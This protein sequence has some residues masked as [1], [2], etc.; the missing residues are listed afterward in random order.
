MITLICYLIAGISISI[1]FLPAFYY[2]DLKWLIIPFM[3][4][5][6]FFWPLLLVIQL[7]KLLY[8]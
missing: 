6:T 4:I 7:A 3:L 5:V 1:H 2:L 8:D